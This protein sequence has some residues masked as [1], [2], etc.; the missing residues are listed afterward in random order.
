MSKL[1]GHSYP[2]D[3]EPE[4]AEKW[5]DVL[6][7]E[8]GGRAESKEAFAQSVGHKSTSSGTYKRKVADARKY[9]LMTPRGDYEATE[10]GFQLANPRD[11]Y[12]RHEVIQEM[13]LN[14]PLLHDIHD[15][16]NASRTPEEFWRVLTELTDANPK[17]ARDAEEWLQKLYEELK[18]ATD[19]LEKEDN[20][21]EETEESKGTIEPELPDNATS[22]EAQPEIQPTPESEIFIKVGNDE[23][24]F[25]ELTD[26]NIELGQQFLETK[27]NTEE[28][29]D[30]DE[31]MKQT[32]FT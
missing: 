27:K 26:V 2:G 4:E 22:V 19:Y 23:L 6:V 8:F 32:R 13:L 30:S 20:P 17:E 11:E 5:T 7:N 28:R 3:L 14:N 21:A 31:E 16:L 25:E 15:T 9:G 24:K 10:L 1:A 12:E 18:Q 29:E